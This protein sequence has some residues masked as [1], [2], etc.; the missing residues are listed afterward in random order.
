MY[1][2][3]S[4]YP[5]GVNNEIN[6]KEYD[7]V[8]DLLEKTFAKWSSKTAY[9][10]LGKEL[11]FTEIDELSTHFAAYLQNECGV[12]KGDR[13]AIQMPNLLQYPVVM[14]GAIKAGAIVVNTNP[15][16]TAGEMKHQF[17]DSEAKVLIILA[18]FASNYEKIKDETSI[19]KVIITEIGDFLGGLKGSIVNLAVKYIKKMVPSYNLPEAVKL[20]D[21]MKRG[22]SAAYTRPEVSSDDVAFLQYTGGT[23]GVSKGAMLTHQNILSNML[24]IFEW[25]K[26]C[27]EEG[28]ETVVTALPL[29][30][31]FAL[32]VNCLSMLKFGATNVLITNP[33]DMKAFIKDLGKYPFSVLTGVNTLFNGLLN[34]ED[35]RKLDFSAL[36][37]TVGGGMAVQQS[38]AKNWEELT[39][40]TLVEGYGLTESSPVLTCNPT[41]GTLQLGTIGVPVPS[42]EVTIR[43]DDGNEVPDGQPGEIWGRGPQV[44]KGY[45][46]RPDETAKTLH[47]DWLKT[48]DIGLVTETGFFKIVDRKKEMVCVSGFNVYP[49][50]VEEILSRHPKVLEV[51]VI[52]VPDPRSTEVV[53]AFIV[54][55]D[56]SLTE[57]E[58]KEFAKEHMT[59]YKRPKHVEFKDELPKS[60]VGK[61]LR[62]LLKEADQKAHPDLWK[63]EED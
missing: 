17:R 9:I 37:V 21:A 50:E 62:R 46:R 48:G 53:K 29:Y 55:K 31:I 43:D 13:V 41:D 56:D 45:W 39:G 26:P 54:K 14:F 51:G 27:L 11:S 7:S 1:P 12:Q 59:G 8:L 60:N 6:P 57:E 47:D 36:K 52:G 35:F 44:M 23:T 18:N 38:V 2:W 40:C 58:V 42:T 3:L 61:I 49:N 15:L 25:Q 16:Y 4:K 19:E 5:E 10:N 32:T 20:K 63:Q 34:Q 33:R 22:K 28:K 30:H 24:Q